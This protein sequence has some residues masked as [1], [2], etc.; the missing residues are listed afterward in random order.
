MIFS[1]NVAKTKW[2]SHQNSPVFEQ[3]LMKFAR[4]FTEFREVLCH[5][6]SLD[7]FLLYIIKT[8]YFGCQCYSKYTF[9]SQHSIPSGFLVFSPD[10]V[11]FFRWTRTTRP[12][13][14]R[15]PTTSATADWSPWETSP[16][17]IFSLRRKEKSSVPTPLESS[18]QKWCILFPSL[19][20][21][22]KKFWRRWVTFCEIAE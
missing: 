4:N 17:G 13:A 21:Q 7:S 20:L 8:R 3:I 9:L 6:V 15:T 19:Y 16:A 2:C 1:A 14:I 22:S 11:A 12:N 18:D 10:E 5:V